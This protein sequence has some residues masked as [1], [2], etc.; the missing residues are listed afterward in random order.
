MR[1]FIL[2]LLLSTNAF[3]G[4]RPP[5]VTGTP[6]LIVDSKMLDQHWVE[7]NE[8]FA[9]DD[10]SVVEGGVAPGAHTVI[11]FTVA[12]PNIGDADVF[13]GDPNVHVA[14]NDGLYE[15]ASCHHH[16]HFRHYAQYELV[17]PRTGFV[18]KAAKRGFCMIDIDPA[19]MTDGPTKTWAYRNC[20][21][22]GIPG[23]QGI[24][25][26]WADVYVW[27]LRGQFFV[28]DGGDGQ[29]PVP[30]GQYIIRITVNPAFVPKKGEPCPHLDSKGL[31]HQLPESN[32]DD[33]IGQATVT[34][35]DHPAMQGTGPGAL[36]KEPKFN[37][38]HDDV[39]EPID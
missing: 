7:R 15:F 29:P 36:D 14:N 32:Y 8:N 22:V 30:P 38:T 11:R 31:C 24:S 21:R 39:G 6:N 18:W 34:I 12:T 35:T 9:G 2:A 5:D 10:C 23:N 20:G 13:L 19:T 33:N 26:A 1:W 3:A 25:R 4:D 17:D 27:Q 16:F 37:Q 28:L